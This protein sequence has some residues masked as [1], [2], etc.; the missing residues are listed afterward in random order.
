MD[1][2]NKTEKWYILY[3]KEYNKN[4][5]IIWAKKKKGYKTPG[6]QVN[7]FSGAQNN[8]NTSM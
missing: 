7:Q 5:R 3:Q 6:M 1:Q 4:V 8:K 2:S